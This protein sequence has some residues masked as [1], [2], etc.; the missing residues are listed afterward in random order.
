MHGIYLK[1]YAL[2]ALARKTSW[3]L[4]TAAVL[5]GP[6]AST[7]P[8]QRPGAAGA[9]LAALP[10]L[11]AIAIPSDSGSDDDLAPPRAKGPARS[12]VALL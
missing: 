12:N 6:L 4:V 5:C 7:A 11:P 2:G 9:E 3:G 1:A 8:H 10:S